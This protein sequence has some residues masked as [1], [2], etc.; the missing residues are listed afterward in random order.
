VGSGSGT[1]A[2]LDSDADAA[3][4]TEELYLVVTDATPF[5]AAIAAHTASW[6]RGRDGGHFIEFGVRSVEGELKS[7][8]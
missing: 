8:W 2:V 4:D 7:D 3:N 1:D 5:L 6:Y